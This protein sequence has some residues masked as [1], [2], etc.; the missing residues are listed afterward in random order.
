MIVSTEWVAERLDDPSLV[1]L[2]IG[3]RETYD[4]VHLPG[5]HYVDRTELS[6]PMGE[7]LMLEMPPLT[8]LQETFEAMGVNEDSRIVLYWGE[9]WVTP[10]ARVY[11]TLDYLG[12]GNRTSIMDGGMPA[13]VLED[14]QVT[15]EVLSVERGSF[16][17]MVRDDVLA[18]IDWVTTHADDPSVA[19]LDARNTEF[20]TGARSGRDMRAGH[21]PGARSLPF[22]D[23]FE[24]GTLKFLDRETLEQLY[25]AAGA[26]PGD[27]V[28]SYCH[29]GQ[30][31]SLIYFVAKYLG[32]DARMYDGSF[33]EWSSK[34]EMPVEASTG[35]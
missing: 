28:V 35:I 1:L 6:T 21:I 10:T 32:Y 34:E 15:S 12:L 3:Q 27:G 2:H 4:A 26:D 20:Y 19:L 24:E 16:T 5:A 13:W 14:R 17:P 18:D 30:Q 9:D 25:L 31:A 23:V 29:I 33:E 22:P 11:L 8:Q 7:G